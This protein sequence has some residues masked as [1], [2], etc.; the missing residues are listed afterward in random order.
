MDD[1]CWSETELLPDSEVLT[2]IGIGK[3]LLKSSYNGLKSINL[4]QK[5][6]K[7]KILKFYFLTTDDENIFNV[8]ILSGLEGFALL[9]GIDRMLSII[10]YRSS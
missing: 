10:G 5:K 9:V 2:S 1:E 8:D 7:K 6:K 4:P 3:V